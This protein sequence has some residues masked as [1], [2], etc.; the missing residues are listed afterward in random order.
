MNFLKSLFSFLLVINAIYCIN[1]PSNAE[2][3]FN[4]EYKFKL[5]KRSYSDNDLNSKFFDDMRKELETNPIYDDMRRE[6]EN[7][8]IYDD[9]RKEIENNPIYDD[10]R[11]EMENNSNY[12]NM[13]KE[14]ET[15]PIY[16]D[17][18]LEIEEKPKK[19]KTTS[20]KQIIPTI[21]SSDKC[22]SKKDGIYM[23]KRSYC[24]SK[25]GYCGKSSAYCDSG[26]QSR[27][28]KCW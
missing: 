25:Y 1:L 19:T 23:C 22:G 11:K 3:N 8:P 13:R 6:L 15:N 21:L 10:M 27:Y 17:M 12:D 16:N 24:C 14:M 7:N 5:T 4:E 2:G 26:C 18:R 28:G 9:M 20:K